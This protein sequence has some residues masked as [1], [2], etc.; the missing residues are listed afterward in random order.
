M[1]SVRKNISNAYALF[2]QNLAGLLNEFAV[3]D[4]AEMGMM[5][6]NRF[7]EDFDFENEDYNPMLDENAEIGNEIYLNIPAEF[8]RMHTVREK[9]VGNIEDPKISVI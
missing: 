3:R 2:G 5:F 4:K 9:E 6:R 7:K 1:P 8:P